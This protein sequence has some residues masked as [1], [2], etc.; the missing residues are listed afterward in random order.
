[1]YSLHPVIVQG[2]YSQQQQPSG[3]QPH[4]APHAHQHQ[5][6]ATQESSGA[7]VTAQ[8]MSMQAPGGAAGASQYVQIQQVGQRP[9]QYL[10]PSVIYPQQVQYTRQGADSSQQMGAQMTY[11]PSFAPAQNV[12]FVQIMPGSN[13]ARL[14]M[15]IQAYGAPGQ[16]MHR[17]TY[18]HPGHVVPQQMVQIQPQ[19]PAAAH[20]QMHPPHSPISSSEVTIQEVRTQETPPPR[21]KKRSPERKAA[22]SVS[23]S[24]SSSAKK[25]GGS[26]K[27]DKD[28]Y[29]VAGK[30]PDT[31]GDLRVVFKMFRLL[32][33]RKQEANHAE[34]KR[35]FS[36]LSVFFRVD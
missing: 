1:M 10:Q 35:E 15:P 17:L 30:D 27:F 28:I 14:L 11:Q 29:E 9:M 16:G 26:V 2:S 7:M 20:V 25:A 8:P 4:D 33:R 18:V 34:G 19:A 3:N 36:E 21:E 6:A 23:A 12:Q 32:R 24:A 22:V 13:G 5:P 31:T